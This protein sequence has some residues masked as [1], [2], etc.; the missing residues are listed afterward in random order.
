M[1]SPRRKEATR[2]QGPGAVPELIRKWELRLGVKVAG[3]FLQRM[4]TK[5]G[6]SSPQRRTVRLNLELAKFPPEYLDYVVLHEVAHFV[7]PTHCERFRA[8]LD[9]NMPGWRN[10]RDRLNEGPLTE[11]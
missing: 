3:Y 1:A 10:I 6:S 5:W 4:K 8:V 11:I 9:C 2:F 7:V